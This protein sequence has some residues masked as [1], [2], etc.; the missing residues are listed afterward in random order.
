MKQ[1]KRK[2]R[3]AKAMSSNNLGFTYSKRFA[4]DLDTY[5]KDTK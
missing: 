4:N 5:I 3:N 1:E 2:A